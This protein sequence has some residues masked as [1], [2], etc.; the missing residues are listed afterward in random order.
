MEK[1]KLK[2]VELYGI[3]SELSGLQIQSTGQVLIKG[4]INETGNLKLGIKGI[5]EGQ[6]RIANRN[7]K[8]ISDQIELINKQRKANDDLKELEGVE[9][10][11]KYKKEK[12]E[13]I[14][15][16]SI[17]IELE[18]FDASKLEELCFEGNYPNIQAKLYK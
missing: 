11:E 17:E 2:V 16:D 8:L 15:N 3:S 1:I 18:P 10:I 14:L 4:F 6:K 5:T 12:E 9:D 13:E 7:I